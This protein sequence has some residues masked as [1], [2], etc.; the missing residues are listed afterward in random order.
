MN[1][2]P[3]HFGFASSSAAEGVRLAVANSS[4][5]PD[6]GRPAAAGPS[7][8]IQFPKRPD[9]GVLSEMIP[10]YYIAQNSRG[11]WLA[12]EAEGRCGGLFLLRRSAV[13]FARQ[14]SAP[15]SCAMMFFSEV[16]ELDVENT[17]SRLVAPVA[18]AMGIATR[19]TPTFA[20]FVAMAITER[21]K[22]VAQVSRAFTGERKNRATVV[23]GLFHGHSTSS[24]KNDEDDLPVP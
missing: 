1:G 19:R 16:L 17:G 8:V 11:F 22:L 2:L 12:R 13:R 4:H 18:A 23:K 14:K 5:D 20:A 6:L 7:T 21:R 9:P 10:L 24:S 3:K 15:A